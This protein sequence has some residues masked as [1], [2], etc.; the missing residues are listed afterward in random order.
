MK[1]RLTVVYCDDDE[2]SVRMFERTFG[3]DFC[4]LPASGADE[5]FELM[6]GN[7][8]DVL[9]TDQMMP[10]ETGGTGAELIERVTRKFPSVKSA[11]VTAYANFKDVLEDAVRHTIILKPYERA[12]ILN[13]AFA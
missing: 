12:E 5:A 1:N 4:V 7:Y 6:K 2:A 13:F 10:K 3:R 8:V 11:I 9:F